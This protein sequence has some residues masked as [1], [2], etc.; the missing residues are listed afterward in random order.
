[1]ATEWFETVKAELLARNPFRE[2]EYFK[3]FAAGTLSPEQTWGHVS[4]WY[5]LICWFPRM[6]S[7]IHSRCDELLVRKDCARHLLVEDLGYFR[8]QI[9]GTPD[10]VELYQRIGDD[11]G[12]PRDAWEGIVPMREM[13]DILAYFRRLAH[14][15]PWSAALCTTAFIED[16]VVE[17]SRTVGRALAEHYGCRPDWG[18]MNYLVH[19]EVEREEAGETEHAILQYLRTPEDRRAAEQSMREMHRLLESYAR[20]LGRERLSAR[21]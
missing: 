17:I 13:S 6:F 15:I 10:H 1:M 4:Q 21:R 20:G 18:A 12:Y 3:A 2:S 14:E 5:L 9:G 7:G 16:E 11:M 8:G 19:E